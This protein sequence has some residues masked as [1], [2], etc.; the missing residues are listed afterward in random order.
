MDP[1]RIESLVREVVVGLD[2]GAWE[3]PARALVEG[4]LDTWRPEGSLAPEPLSALLTAMLNGDVDPA[5]ARDRLLQMADAVVPAEQRYQE[6]LEIGTGGMGRVALA[7]DRR[8]QRQVARK[9]LRDEAASPTSRARFAREARVTARMEHPNIVPV[10]DLDQG[11]GGLVLTMKVVKGRSL[12]HALVAGD[13]PALPDRLRLFLKIGDAIAFAHSRGVIHRDLKPDNVMVGEFGEVQVMDWG[14]ARTLGT[15]DA[16]SSASGADVEEGDARLTRAHSVLGTPAYMAPEQAL[17]EE[18]GPGTDIWALGAI[19]WELAVGRR[20]REG[21]SSEIFGAARQGVVP[22]PRTV[23]PTVSR[24]LEAVIQRAMARDAAQRYPAVEALRRDVE[25]VLDGRPVSARATAWWE[26]LGKGARRNARVLVPVGV[27]VSLALAGLAV[28]LARQLRAVA[29]ARDQAE[30][31]SAEARA[32]SRAAMTSLADARL[33]AAARAYQDES[34]R[35]REDL[36]KARADA[37]T[38]EDAGRIERA[39]LALDALAIADPLPVATVA[40][41]SDIDWLT[42]SPDGT[43]VRGVGA[44]GALARVALPSGEVRARMPPVDGLVGGGW[45]DDGRPVR[46]RV[47]DGAVDLTT[48]TGDPVAQFSIPPFELGGRV[49]LLPGG[50]IAVG[51]YR[52]Q[53]M[54]YDL[55]RL[56]GSAVGA[57]AGGGERAYPS[58]VPGVRVQVDDGAALTAVDSAGRR[59]L[60]GEFE[61]LVASRAGQLVILRADG[62]AELWDGLANRRIWRRDDQRRAELGGALGSDLV[63][64]H[65]MGRDVDVRRVTDGALV[66][67]LG[68]LDLARSIGWSEPFRLV[69]VPSGAEL[70]LIPVGPAVED[71]S[72]AGSGAFVVGLSPDG[73]LAATA[74]RLDTVQIWDADTRGLQSRLD[75]VGCG[76]GAVTFVGPVTLAVVCR[77]G[78]EVRWIDLD[79]PAATPRVTPLASPATSAAASS[80]GLLVTHR[81]GGLTLLDPATG[82]VRARVNAHPGAIWTAAAAGD[83]A[84]TSGRDTAD[85]TLRAWNLPDLSPR[86]QVQLDDVPFGVATDGV[87]VAIGDNAGHV[88]RYVA[89]TGAEQGVATLQDGLV[90]DVAIAPDG[91]VWSVG[92]DGQVVASRDGV[93]RWA[94]PAFG[95]SPGT[96]VAAAGPWVVAVSADGQVFW[97]ETGIWDRVSGSEPPSIAARWRAGGVSTPLTSPSP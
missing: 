95:Q 83:L 62:A 18:T 87:T 44:D 14:L 61:K 16:P 42:V 6:L 22:A 74:G 76:V 64:I 77:V 88:H 90:L 28:G 84:F 52:G 96:G 40:F 56:D 13:I 66:R 93:A 79:H 92:W 4:S 51:R 27:A 38:L 89:S 11:E 69:L 3:A 33:E 94:W 97:H 85:R 70:R 46:L 10:Y 25:A 34:R 17:G 19:L 36:L 72:D 35:A 12:A 20:A 30:V 32:Q 41:A 26:R 82:A 55:F 48:D 2:S 63:F 54:S 7:F 15:P 5:S 86:W 39:S 59:L 24:D 91:M 50:R 75:L 53:V 45:L 29:A 37:V 1:E 78:N 65:G 68:H 49:E 57:A 9:T 58:T 67:R 23:N 43:Q 31:A 47:A 71:P 21:S 80:A 73:R 8:L 60:G 81:D